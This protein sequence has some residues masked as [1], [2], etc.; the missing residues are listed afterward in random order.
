MRWLL[1]FILIVSFSC[2]KPKPKVVEKTTSVIEQYNFYSDS[3]KTPFPYHAYLP[4][5]YEKYDSLPVLYLLHGHNEIGLDWFHHDFGDMKTIL[6]TLIG[7]Q[8]IPP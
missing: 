2:Q 6:D 7:N 1:G 8:H 4:A 5:N 3:L